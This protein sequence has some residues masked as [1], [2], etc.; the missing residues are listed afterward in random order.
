MN[1]CS[2]KLVSDLCIRKT[3]NSLTAYELLEPITPDCSID[4]ACITVWHGVQCFE[5]KVAATC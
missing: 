4:T 5:E 1:L 3:V 2:V